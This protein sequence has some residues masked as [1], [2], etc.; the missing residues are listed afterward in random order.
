MGLG[1]A[2]VLVAL[3]LVGCSSRLLP[4]TGS[5]TQG[6][7]LRL[8]VTTPMLPLGNHLTQAYQRVNPSVIFETVGGNFTTSRERLASDPTSYMLTNHLPDER[9]W[10]APL[11]QDGI[12]VIVN[13]NM[14][15]TA[16][17]M[18]DLR[19]VYR[20]RVADWSE[21]GGRA[22]AITVVT[23]ESGS[24]TRAEFE[25]LVMGNRE[26]TPAAQIASSSAV[27][28]EIVARTPGAV[29]YVSMSYLDSSV[30]ALVI[31]GIMPSLEN[32]AN[33]TYPLRSI[34]YIA[35]YHE[36]ELHYRNFIYWAQTLEGQMVVARRYA[37][38]INLQP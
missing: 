21:L 1:R 28:V 4:A 10:A 2:V 20:G 34:I 23:R 25:R 19:E 14:P 35:G 7:A 24:G 12:A 32:V 15:I 5:V 30:R 31:D 8:Y 17:T 18:H 33:N 9:L 38:L 22:A 6:I 3:M 26:V 37:P 16:L 29:G 11:G 36:P 27:M 13:A